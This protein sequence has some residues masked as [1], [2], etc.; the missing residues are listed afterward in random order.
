LGPLKRGWLG[1]RPLRD[2]SLW[3]TNVCETYERGR[4]ITNFHAALAFW[5]YFQVPGLQRRPLRRVNGDGVGGGAVANLAGANCYRAQPI[6]FEE[7]ESH[8]DEPITEP[9][10]FIGG[11][12]DSGK[13]G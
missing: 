10:I 1:E 4:R 8:G 12:R 13:L 3:E 6:D 9:S 5:V 11:E 2:E 7:L